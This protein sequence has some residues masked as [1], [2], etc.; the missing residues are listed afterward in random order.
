MKSWLEDNGIEMYSTQKEGK[1]VV[2]ERFNRTL[3]NKNYKYMTSIARNVYIGKLDD[4]VD[5]YNN[6]YHSAIKM[7]PV[8][9]KS[10]TYIDCN[11]ENTEKILS[12]MLMTM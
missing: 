12:L 3:N 7:R 2:A 4:I 8:D 5:K 9:A 11:K 1:S 10:R 6:T